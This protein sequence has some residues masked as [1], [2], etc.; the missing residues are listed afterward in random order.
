MKNVCTEKIYIYISFFLIMA[1]D[2]QEKQIEMWKNNLKFSTGAYRQY[3]WSS[4]EYI[5]FVRS[6]LLLLRQYSML[7]RNIV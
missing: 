2:K 3:A 5:C 7:L 1:Q 4:P 6:M